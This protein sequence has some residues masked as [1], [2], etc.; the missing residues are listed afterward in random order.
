MKHFLNALLLGAVVSATAQQLPEWQTVD[1]YN[2]GQL[3][4][5]ALV[6]PY[7]DNDASAIRDF[8]YEESPYYMS[9]NGKWK[10]S[11]VKGV[12][13]R[14]VGFQNPQYD[15]SS[16]K[17]INVPGNWERQGY[18]TAVYVNTTY[19][20]DTEWA[21]FK[22]NEPLVPTVTNEVG[23]YRRS[24][25]IPASWKGRRV[26]L[27]CEGII[28]FYYVWVNG[29]LLGCNMDSKTAAEWDITKYLKDGENTVAMEVYRW[30]AGASSSVRILASQRHRAR[31]VSLLDPDHIY[32]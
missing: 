25:T 29:Q 19:E 28:S 16:W 12:D 20:F 2:V 13:K 11:W 5:H 23:S 1:A 32:F 26:V 3:P 17:L 4:S 27:C 24:F 6:V 30:S 8:K 31:R 7:P 14:L 21:D 15:V 18:G 9:L 10:F 22:K